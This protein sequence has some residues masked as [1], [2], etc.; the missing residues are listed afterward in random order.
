MRHLITRIPFILL[1]VMAAPGRVSSG[2]D[3]EAVA[4]DNIQDY[5]YDLAIDGA[6]LEKGPT[7]SEIKL[8][9]RLEPRSRD[10]VKMLATSAA[11]P[12]ALVAIERYVFTLFDGAE[13]ATEPANLFPWETKK[14]IR[15]FM[16]KEESAARSLKNKKPT[17][18]I[19]AMYPNYVLSKT[20]VILIED[21]KQGSS[22]RVRVG[23][24]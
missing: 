13:R 4:G 3:A 23:A 21:L 16:M 15:F 5:H 11:D 17:M 1:I 9:I 12:V 18:V 22:L 20:P 6:T 19:K 7:H 8:L 2:V 24:E 14:R 10:D